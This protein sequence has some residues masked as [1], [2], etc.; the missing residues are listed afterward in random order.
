M[1]VQNAMNII[2]TSG[3]CL[4]IAFVTLTASQF[5]LNLHLLLSHSIYIKMWQMWR[6]SN[7]EKKKPTNIQKKIIYAWLMC[8][9]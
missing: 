3:N 8:G 2:N 9:I 4:F 6:L 1:I 5:V 7:L